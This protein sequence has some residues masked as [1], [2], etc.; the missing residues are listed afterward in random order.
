MDP[1]IVN[2]LVGHMM[3]HGGKLGGGERDAHTVFEYSIPTSAFP[4]NLHY[5]ALG[6]LHRAQ[7]LPGRVPVE[8]SGSLLHLDFGEETDEKSVTLIDADPNTPA[9]SERITLKSGRRLR[10][11]RGSFDELQKRA[12]QCGDD[13]LRVEITGKV[14]AGLADDVRALL[15][16]AVEVRVAQRATQVTKLEERVK[17][18]RGSPIDLFQMYLKEQDDEDGSVLTLFKE[19]LEECDASEAS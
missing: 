9:R 13:Y 16:N 7:S 19:L 3:V 1:K 8:Y 2:V 17:A 4:A 18:M 14:S 6:H 11:I 10:T 15:P 12:S 5:V